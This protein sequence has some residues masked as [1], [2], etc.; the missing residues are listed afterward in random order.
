MVELFK[1]SFSFFSVRVR[2]GPEKFQVVR[3]YDTRPMNHGRS[4]HWENNTDLWGFLVAS[5]RD[6]QQEN[7][8]LQQEISKLPTLMIPTHDPRIFTPEDTSNQLS[9]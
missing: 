1:E 4:I 3:T 2:K 6:I 9:S 7:E 8:A 5:S